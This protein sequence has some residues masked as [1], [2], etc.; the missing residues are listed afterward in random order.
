MS[1][2]NFAG[3][4]IVATLISTSAFAQAEA[5]YKNDV[6]H[7]SPFVFAGA[8]GLVFDPKNFAGASAQGTAAFVYGAG[9]DFK[10][11][12]YVFVLAEYRGLVYNSPAFDLSE[13]NGL[14]RTT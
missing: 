9:A 1:R 5:A 13:F 14:D 7:W 6:A 4:M 2:K 11:W 3:A 10:L 8:G 12:Q